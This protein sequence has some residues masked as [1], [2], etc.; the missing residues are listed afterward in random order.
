[1]PG[2]HNVIQNGQAG[3]KFDIL[4]GSRDAKFGNLVGR[5]SGDILPLKINIALLRAIESV[6]TVEEAALPGTIWTY[7][8]QYLRPSDLNINT[9]QSTELSEI[10]AN[11]FDF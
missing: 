6:Y 5:Q 11:I 7:D 2:R 4:E 1:M 8:S 9:I 10:Q 3:I